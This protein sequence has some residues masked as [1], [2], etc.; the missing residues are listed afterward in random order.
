MSTS[1]GTQRDRGRIA[2]IWAWVCIALVPVAYVVATLVG[3]AMLALAGV[4]EGSTVRPPTAIVLPIGL[5]SIAVLIAPPVAAI[6]LGIRAARR[7]HGSGVVAAV[8]GAV[9]VTL[10]IVL[11]FLPFAIG[12]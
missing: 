4:D 3:G 10:A 7:G 1:Q 8:L 5:V 2:V 9:V 6:V 12:A 11:N